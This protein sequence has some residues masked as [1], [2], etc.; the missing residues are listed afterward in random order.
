MSTHSLSAFLGMFLGMVLSP[1]PWQSTVVPL[2]VQSAGH[3]VAALHSSSIRMH[4]STS[5]PTEYPPLA[6]MILET[7]ALRLV[8]SQKK[9]A[10]PSLF[11]Q[12]LLFLF[13]EELLRRLRA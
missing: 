2:Q 10:A 6:G 4:A 5:L 7:R 1:S 12:T 11:A 3:A 9:K 13:L 8:L